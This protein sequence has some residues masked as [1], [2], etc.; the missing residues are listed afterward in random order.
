MSMCEHQSHVLEYQADTMIWLEA[1][2]HSIYIVYKLSSYSMYFT[3]LQWNKLQKKFSSI[4]SPN[5]HV[6]LFSYFNTNYPT[7]KNSSHL[8]SF[9]LG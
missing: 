5:Q 4:T 1:Q 2:E 9:S 7:M 6:T 3:S 8:P